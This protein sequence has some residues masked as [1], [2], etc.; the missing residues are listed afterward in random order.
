MGI[1]MYRLMAVNSI[2]ASRLKMSNRRER[3][4]KHN[5]P[6]PPAKRWRGENSSWPQQDGQCAPPNHR[7]VSINEG[8]G[9]A[10]DNHTIVR[11]PQI[12]SRLGDLPGPTSSQ[13]FNFD[14]RRVQQHSPRD[15]NLGQRLSPHLSL[16]P[17]PTKRQRLSR[18]E[19]RNLP[20][21]DEQCLHDLANSDTGKMI[22]ELAKRG[23]KR[24]LGELLKSKDATSGSIAL[25]LLVKMF[26]K[27]GDLFKS[28]ASHQPSTPYM[29]AKLKEIMRYL[30]ESDTFGGFYLSLGSFLCQMP[31][32]GSPTRRKELLPILH[33]TIAMCNVLLDIYPGQ[34]SGSLSI[35]DTCIGTA[36]QL[37]Q[38]QILF[39]EV[40]EK[41]QQL[42]RKRNDI[43]TKSF[44]LNC[45]SSYDQKFSVVLPPPEQLHQDMLTLRKNEISGAFPDASIYLTTQ[46]QLLQEDF[47]KPLRDALQ[48]VNP[49]RNDLQR[50]CEDDDERQSVMVYR[51]I[52][53]DKGRTFTFSGVAYRISFKTPRKIK[54]NRSKKLQYGSLV[55]LSTDNFRTLLYAT[56][57]E[58]DAE[59]LNNGITSIQLQDCSPDDEMKISSS[60]QF[61]MIESPG[62]YEAYAPV[63]KRL[64]AIEPSELP[65]KD[66]LVDLKTD[67]DPPNYFKD[68]LPILD[69]KGIVCKCSGSHCEH[70]NMDIFDEE[71]WDT[72]PTPSL[73]P[74]QKKALHMALT[75]EMAL[76]QGP[77]G[78]GKTYVGLKL[79]EAFLR[80]QF[81]W[82]ATGFLQAKCPI[83]VICYTN[84]ALDQ[85]LEGILRLK[86]DVQVR[87][88]GSRTKSENIRELNIQKFVHRYCREHRIF[89]PMKSWIEKQKL[90]KAMEEFI[91]GQYC[92]E[93]TR[94]YC[95]FLSSYVTEDIQDSCELPLPCP[96]R[97]VNEY[98]GFASWLDLA[99]Q[100][101]ITHY[102]EE[103]K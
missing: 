6:P 29:E 58:R 9:Y 19:P 4:R 63:L 10:I 64:H 51:D 81:L 49:L 78:T 84:H 40:S 93:K 85:F 50:A 71:Q 38:Q 16:R 34:A 54:W 22:D 62:Y 65:F 95:Y 75:K 92:R 69:L 45:E 32:E 41:A 72:L 89:N 7:L 99:L 79:I 68:V 2:C 8:S 80:N 3:K 46:F 74:S 53:F 44:E 60:M 28:G 18:P 48:E 25:T 21:S 24:E 96:S 90:V 77:P 52:H 56:I 76:I 86:L 70:E 94:L 12:F 11:P 87:R 5:Q 31:T 102:Y 98:G 66:Y 23:R 101:K 100:N 14:G 15:T 82:E 61:S 88:I 103:R 42:L 59:D 97:S 33:D 83:V 13:R 26:A 57:V 1:Q 43:R 35:I 17:H 91:N 39:Q 55:C 27:L 37:G 20:L 30:I 47:L 67:V 73:D 36:T